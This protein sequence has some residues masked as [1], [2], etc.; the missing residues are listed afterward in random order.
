[1][2]VLYYMWAKG[3]SADVGSGELTEP[4]SRIT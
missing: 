2:E 3:V 4:A 1:V